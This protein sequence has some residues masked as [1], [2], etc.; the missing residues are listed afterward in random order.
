MKEIGYKTCFVSPHPMG[1]DVD[2]MVNNIGFDTVVRGNNNPEILPD[3][4]TYNIIFNTIEKYYENNE[5]FLICTYIEGTHAGRDSPHKKYKDGSDPCYNKFYN[6]DYWFGE[7]VN[8]MESKGYFND[9]LLVFTA[10]HSSFP[11]VDFIKAFNPKNKCFID[12]IPLFFYKTGIVPQV[13]DAENKNSLCLTPTIL[14]ILEESKHTNFFLGNSLFVKDKNPYL[15]F[16]VRQSEFVN[17]ETGK[18]KWMLVP[19]R[20]L[21]EIIT[22][23]YNIFG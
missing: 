14:N 5:K 11:T 3:K 7:F 12:R 22:R 4:E 15:R 9:T 16:S 18:A 1:D 13:F 8:K 19:P 2:N 20:D 10:D 21:L 17:T 6:Q 23:Y